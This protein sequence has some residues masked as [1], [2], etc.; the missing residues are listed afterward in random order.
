MAALCRD[1]G[2][3]PAS[4][5]VH[6]YEGTFSFQQAQQQVSDALRSL[7]NLRLW[8]VD[9]LQAYFEGEDDSHNMQMFDAAKNFR[10]LS[11]GHPNRPAGTIL[12]HPAR[13][14]VATN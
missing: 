9:S 14:Q 8:M 5:P 12:C 10:I 2:I 6:W 3:D 13:M 7:P 4:L 1:L 11:E